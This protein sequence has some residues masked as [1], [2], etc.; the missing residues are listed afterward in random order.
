MADTHGVGDVKVEVGVVV[1]DADA[2]AAFYGDVIGLPYV[3]DLEFGGGSMRRY[4]HGDAVVKLVST[5]EPPALSNPPNG[6][7]G[8]ASGA[9]GVRYLTL[10]V[11]DVEETVKRCLDAGRTVPVPRFEF[12]PGVFIAMV[13]DPDGNWVELVQPP[14]A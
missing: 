7:A 2:M 8:G 6:P 4:A 10:Q 13:E 9:S 12:Q 3:G 1:R 14:A 5:A 11:D